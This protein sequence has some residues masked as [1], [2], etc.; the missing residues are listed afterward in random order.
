MNTEYYI[1]VPLK[2]VTDVAAN[3]LFKKKKEEVDPNQVDEIEYGSDKTHYV[4]VKISGTPEN[5][6]I[7]LGKK[8]VKK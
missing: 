4:N 7:S 3:K 1:K 5:M 2:L 6:S 8:T